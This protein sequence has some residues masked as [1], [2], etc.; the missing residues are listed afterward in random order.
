MHRL[1]TNPARCSPGVGGSAR[2]DCLG[3][4]EWTQL[5]LCWVLRV[6]VAQ[7]NEKVVGVDETADGKGCVVSLKTK[8]A[9]DA[10]K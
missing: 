5:S 6:L 2:A 4:S 3:A 10:S 7:A 8:K 1:A 9:E